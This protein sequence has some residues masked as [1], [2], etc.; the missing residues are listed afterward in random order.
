M[1]AHYLNPLYVYYLM[2]RA[3]AVGNITALKHVLTCLETVVTV[4]EVSRLA[5]KDRWSDSPGKVRWLLWFYDAVAEAGEYMVV[6][7]GEYLV[8]EAGVY[9]WVEVGRYL[10]VEAEAGVYLVVEAGEYLVVE[11]GVY[12]VVEA[13]KYLMVEAGEYPVVEAGV[14]GARF[15]CDLAVEAGEYLV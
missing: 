1:V 15:R 9:L 8:V 4:D 10:V 11:A 12:L 6:E 7:A 5:G 2:H 14:Y 13:G 3:L